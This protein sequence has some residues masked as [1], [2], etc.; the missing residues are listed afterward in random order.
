MNSKKINITANEEG[1]DFDLLQTEW[2]LLACS[3]WP[4]ARFLDSIDL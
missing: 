1:C 2:N 3:M 4:I